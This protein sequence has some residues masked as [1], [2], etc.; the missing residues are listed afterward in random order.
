LHAE[1]LFVFAF[2]LTV[3]DAKIKAEEA[4]TQSVTGGGVGKSF[5][6]VIELLW[7]SCE[8]LKSPGR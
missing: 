7:T 3:A 4:H 5:V 8:L 1:G 6:S 2:P